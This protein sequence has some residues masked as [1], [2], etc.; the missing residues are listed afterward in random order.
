MGAPLTGA[1]LVIV[2]NWPDDSCAAGDT[3]ML[4]TAS[5]LQC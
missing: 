1:G 5:N 3:G 2:G 4:V